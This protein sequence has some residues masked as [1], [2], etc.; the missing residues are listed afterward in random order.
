MPEP[1]TSLT[2]AELARRYRDGSLDP[3]TVTEA[4]L[5]AIEAHPEGGKVYRVVT[6]Q[7]ALKQAR[8][9]KRRFDEGL[10][11]SPMQGVPIAIKDLVGTAG[12]V[13]AAGSRVL[14]ERPAE[15]EDA[16]VAAR[17]DAAG[18]VFLGKT[19]MTELAY[20]GIGANP[21]YGTPGCALDP[22]RIPGGSSSGSGVAVASQLAAVAVGSDTGGS[23][24]IPAAVN[25]IVGLKVTD[26]RIPTDGCAAL[27]TTL[28]T[29]GPL[30]RT[31]EDAW[32]L[33]L[34]MT[35]EPH[36]PLAQAP[37][38]L[39]LLAPTTLLTDDL[40]DATLTGFEQG[41]AR[42]EALGHHVRRE[43]LPILMEAP[44]AYS[45]F[46]SFASHEVWALYQ[47]LFE[48]RRHDFDPHVA[49][50][51]YLYANRPSSDYIRLN[52]ARAD[53][54]RRFWPSLSGVDAVVGPTIPHVPVRIAE[55]LTDDEAYHR[56]NNR[57]LRNTAPFNVLGSPAVSVPV[58]TTVDGLS[59]GLMIV[60]RPLEE[61]LA[62]GVA[63]ALE[64]QGA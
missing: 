39:T 2:A 11:V 20:S 15:V 7:R 38:R 35:A 37:A 16:P 53:F 26:G 10:R 61:E 48:S 12:D 50:R 18:A 60:T 32:A 30:A 40:D 31:A 59:I 56:E 14:G 24:R 55:V 34:A 8:A 63:R 42:L 4:Y 49:D 62:L 45:R 25:G 3:V 36:R 9:A 54:Q 43:P 17:L 22:S 23:V 64:L 21:H 1:I 27:S 33:Y 29:I 44:A 46:G 51:V 19:N 47:D 28:D 13:T 52:Y 58:A 41:L 5:A 57:I 6:A